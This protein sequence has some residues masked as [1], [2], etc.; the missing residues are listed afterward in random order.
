[1]AMRV[2]SK[3][4]VYVNHDLQENWWLSGFAI[5]PRRKAEDLILEGTFVFPNGEMMHA[6][7]AALEEQHPEV[8]YTVEGTRVHFIW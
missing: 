4:H 1:M 6:Y 8:S 3:D 2:Y 7:L 5:G